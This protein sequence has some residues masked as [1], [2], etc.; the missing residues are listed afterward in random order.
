MLIAACGGNG[1]VKPSSVS[2]ITPTSPVPDTAVT[3]HV[4]SDVQPQKTAAVAAVVALWR[5]IDRLENNPKDDLTTLDSVARSQ[6]LTQWQYNIS[7]AR[8]KGE[9]SKG[10]TVVKLSNARRNPLAPESSYTVTACLDVS[11][12]RVF[13]SSGRSIVSRSRPPKVAYRYD[14]IRDS[15]SMKWYVTVAKA[16]GTC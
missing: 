5:Q 14:V 2:S 13:D 3:S 9:T 16:A 10:N 12:V 6:V 8:Q 11:R 1:S 7:T 4:T 15:K